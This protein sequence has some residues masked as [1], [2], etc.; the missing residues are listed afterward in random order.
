MALVV[1]L[2]TIG[3]KFFARGFASSAAVLIGFGTA[4]DG[5]VEVFRYRFGGGL[6]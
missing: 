4:G 3:V 6:C 1:I 5:D 2:T